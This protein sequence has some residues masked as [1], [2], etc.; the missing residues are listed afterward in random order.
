MKK[1][2]PGDNREDMGSPKI[3]SSRD[4]REEMGSPK[5]K[6]S[7]D[8]GE[9]LRSPKDLTA[10]INQALQSV[11]ENEM[12]E[13]KIEHEEEKGKMK[14]KFEQDL[15]KQE[16]LLQD[17]ENDMKTFKEKLKEEVQCPVCLCTPRGNMIPVC[18]QGH[19]ICESCV[20]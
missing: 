7:G 18:N 3:K 14:E 15:E 19:I 8:N 1:E 9:D 20:R 6:G 11:L 17:K 12:N 4:N 2:G 16:K 5:I 13:M 10:K